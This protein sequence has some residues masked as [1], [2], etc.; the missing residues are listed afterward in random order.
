M[1]TLRSIGLVGARILG[2]IVYLVAWLACLFILLVVLWSEQ[3]STTISPFPTRQ[4]HVGIFSYL[5][6]T[7]TP[8]YRNP[9]STIPSSREWYPLRVAASLLATAALLTTMVGLCGRSLRMLLL[10]IWGSVAFLAIYFWFLE[11]WDGNNQQFGL[12]PYYSHGQVL[13]AGAIHSALATA[14]LLL[15]GLLITAWILRSLQAKTTAADQ[16]SKMAAE[17]YAQILE[18]W[19]GSN[20]P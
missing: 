1:S 12:F 16:Q 19:D 10:R 17:R 9:G 6:T 4:T 18:Q 11:S 5:E 2:W 8:D 20:S 13:W 15:A 3:S 7:D 14:V